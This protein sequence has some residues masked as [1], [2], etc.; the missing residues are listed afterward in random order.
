MQVFERR[1]V[2]YDPTAPEGFQLPSA[3]WDGSIMIGGMGAN[4]TRG[5][6]EMDAGR[7]KID[8]FSSG[9]TADADRGGTRS[10]TNEYT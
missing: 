10:G 7:R 4:R 5:G 6:K 2:T 9:P 1:T 3:T 8:G